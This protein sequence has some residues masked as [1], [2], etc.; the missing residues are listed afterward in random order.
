MQH[1]PPCVA[2]NGT[3]LRCPYASVSS[4]MARATDIVL[5]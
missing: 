2:L 3:G 4:S 5:S 1:V